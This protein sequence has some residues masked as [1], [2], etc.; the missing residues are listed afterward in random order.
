MEK[1]E[2]GIYFISTFVAS[3]FAISL[4]LMIQSKFIANT[5]SGA[6]PI[7]QPASQPAVVI[8]QSGPPPCPCPAES[9]NTAS[10]NK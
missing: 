6:A 4:V 2:I 8:N 7:S 5:P 3:F 1:R 10:K 9:S